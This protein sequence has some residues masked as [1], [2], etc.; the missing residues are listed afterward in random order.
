MC[1]WCSG[2]GGQSVANDVAYHDQGWTGILPGSLDGAVNGVHIQPVI[3]S[4]HMPAISFKPFAP[5]FRKGNIRGSFNRNTVVIVEVDQ[6][7]QSQVPGKGGGFRCH[8]LHQV[9][10][11]NN[12][13][14]VMIDDLKPGTIE[15]FCQVGF[16]NC[17]AHPVGK[18]LPKRTGGGLHAG[19]YSIFRV[20]RRDAA[21]LPEVFDIF[22]GHI[23]TR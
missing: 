9:A 16:S 19:G 11:G 6:F 4:L 8:S 13:I 17:H 1:F 21:P 18:A 12:G 14:D 3:H 22:Q 7:S 2:T 15:D 5:I 23:V 10:I 20:T